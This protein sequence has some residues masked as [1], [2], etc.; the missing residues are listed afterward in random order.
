[1][2][3][4]SAKIDFFIVVLIWSVIALT[5]TYLNFIFCCR[6]LHASGN[7]LCMSSTEYPLLLKLSKFFVI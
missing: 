5:K 2:L 6:I 4:S 3:Y 1:M 7:A